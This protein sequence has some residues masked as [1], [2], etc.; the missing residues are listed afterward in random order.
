MWIFRTLCEYYYSN[1][2]NFLL[3][4]FYSGAVASSLHCSIWNHKTKEE[5]GTAFDEFDKMIDKYFDFQ[6]EFE[7]IRKKCRRIF[8][9]ACLLSY[10]M[11]SSVLISNYISSYIYLPYACQQVILAHLNHVEIFQI[12][13]FINGVQRRL[14]IIAEIS[15]SRKFS[16]EMLKL[17]QKAFVDLHEIHQLINDCYK[18][19]LFLNMI[20]IHSSVLI[21]LYWLGIALLGVP[22]AFILGKNTWNFIPNELQTFAIIFRCLKLLDSMHSDFAFNG[23]YRLEVA[24]FAPQNFVSCNNKAS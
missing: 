1:V 16:A 21:N 10:F 20:Q 2:E 17:E 8:V 19:P 18:L 15:N 9:L 22:Y 23:T 11:M 5:I 13:V 24:T 12:F 14:Q 6:L 7:K 4:F 3:V